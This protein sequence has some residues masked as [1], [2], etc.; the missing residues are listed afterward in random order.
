MATGTQQ[1]RA[2][3]AID[4]A[5][6]VRDQAVKLRDEASDLADYVTDALSDGVITPDE[7]QEIK[8]RSSVMKA[9][10]VVMKQEADEVVVAT[11]WN[12]AG[13]LAAVAKLMERDS[14]NAM[15]REAQVVARAREIGMVLHA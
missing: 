12:K 11:K 1:P 6:D 13:Q 8:R 2:D 7:A 4:E 5:E 15:L 9:Q 10:T 3:R 14:V